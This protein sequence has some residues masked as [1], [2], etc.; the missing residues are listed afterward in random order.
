MAKWSII[1]VGDRRDILT[2]PSLSASRQFLLCFFIHFFML[3]CFYWSSHHPILKGVG[4]FRYPQRDT[5]LSLIM[6]HKS[7]YFFL[8]FIFNQNK[9]KKAND[10][11]RNLIFKCLE[12]VFDWK[13][14]CLCRQSNFRY[15]IKHLHEIQIILFICMVYNF[16]ETIKL[17][18]VKV[19]S[20]K[21]FV[22]FI[23]RVKNA[24]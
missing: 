14:W 23:K 9:T 2:L 3:F 11:M 1:I 19:G 21:L 16:H 4:I 15:R 12:A 8:L 24:Q 17:I 7:L 20:S 6:Q 5:S 22:I 13:A 10:I 18:N